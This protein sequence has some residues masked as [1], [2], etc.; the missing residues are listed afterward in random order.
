MDNQSNDPVATEAPVEAGTNTESTETTQTETRTEN[1]FLSGLSDDLR[2]NSGLTKFKDT[3]GLAKSY[4]ELQKTLGKDKAVIPGEGAT[5]EELDGYFSKVGMPE[6]ADDYKF[7]NAENLKLD[8]FKNFAREN[9][10][11]Q[12]Q[13]QAG[14]EW[15]KNQAMANEKQASE[16]REQAI[17][18]ADVELRQELGEAYGESM[19]RAKSFVQSNFP[20][21]MENKDIS[22]GL[23][24][25]PRFIK[26]M[27][28]LSKM[29]GEASING[30]P[31]QTTLT[32]AE[33]QSKRTALMNSDAY[34]NRMNPEHEATVLKARE[35]LQTSLSGQA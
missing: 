7:D 26:D 12:A 10:F 28:K 20:S 25:D 5:P 35:L 15:I 33:A 32:P 17:Q 3:N 13:A 8:G 6:T 18:S 19:A 34:L 2:D 24:N 22:E 27:V 30:V 9:R 1:S 31:K 29:M 21:I 23:G 4:L 14:V 16:Q 11:T